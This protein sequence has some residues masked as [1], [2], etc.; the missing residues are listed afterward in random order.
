MALPF[1]TIIK[2]G[3]SMKIFNILLVGA[4]MAVLLVCPVQ[5]AG[6]YGALNAA[7][8]IDTLKNP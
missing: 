1:L 8:R 3:V 6:P 4:I 7:Y 5:A 2:K